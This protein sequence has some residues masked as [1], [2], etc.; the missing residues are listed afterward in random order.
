MLIKKILGRYNV[1]GEISARLVLN[2]IVILF[3]VFGN[4][5]LDLILYKIDSDLH[6]LLFPFLDQ[7]KRL[8]PLMSSVKFDEGI[9]KELENL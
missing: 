9:V 5:A 1:T 8:P 6:H 7:Q 2:H 4:T 3:N